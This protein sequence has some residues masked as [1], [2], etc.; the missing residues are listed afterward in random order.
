MLGLFSVFSIFNFN[1]EIVSHE[2]YTQDSKSSYEFKYYM[3]MLAPLALAGIVVAAYA[4]SSISNFLGIKYTWLRQ[5]KDYVRNIIGHAEIGQNGLLES[6]SPEQA[7]LPIMNAHDGSDATFASTLVTVFLM[8][9]QL[10]Y[11]NLAQKSVE[12]F[13]C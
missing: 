2:C 6:G 11:L 7:E 8:T 12:I 3:T 4:L 13:N 10:L 9:M 5:V 1:I